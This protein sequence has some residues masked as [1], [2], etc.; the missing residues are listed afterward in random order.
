MA[1]VAVCSIFGLVVGIL[2][3]L[4]LVDRDNPIFTLICGVLG[5]TVGVWFSVG[6]I[7]LTGGTTFNAVMILGVVLTTVIVLLLVLTKI[8]EV[9]R[10][11]VT[12]SHKLSG[13]FAFAILIG[14]AVFLMVSAFPMYSST[15][16][17]INVQNTATGLQLDSSISYPV[18]S[19]V[20]QQLSTVPTC[21]SCG[22]VP[23]DVTVRQ[24]SLNFPFFTSTPSVGD[25]LGLDISFNVG[26]SG[27][28]WA[29]PFIKIAVVHDV[30][31]S[32]TITDA[33][34]FWGS[35]LYKVNKGISKWRTH[36][37]YHE[38]GM[39]NIQFQAVLS[40]QGVMRCPIFHANSIDVWKIDIAKF[41][42]NTPE[43]YLSLTDQISWDYQLTQKE[44][45]TEWGTI[46]K[47]QSSTIN[48]D[49]YCHQDFEGANLLWVGV[50]DAN[51]NECWTTDMGDVL[52]YKI[53][54]FTITGTPDGPTADAHGPYSGQPS[55]NIQFTGSA[56]GG[57]TPYTSWHWAFGDGGSA[58]TQNPV[59]SYSTAGTY[60]ATLTVTDS[61]G[62]TDGD[63]ST[64]TIATSQ[65]DSDGDGIP[66]INDNCPNT[67][68]PNQADA[69]GD[70]IGDACES[71]GQPVVGIDITTYIIAGSLS[72]GCIGTIVYGKKYL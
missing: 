42:H 45:V 46:A 20:V 2:A 16:N 70:G 49:L 17:T 34:D 38:S 63:I 1:Q 14:I 3:S 59:H 55:Q 54:P 67:Y 7:F 65:T 6:W 47:G 41:F 11:V 71:G 28:D 10:L 51:F 58:Y 50:G 26:T 66:D 43:N 69:D 12:T 39:P 8:Q 4:V 29:A 15:T 22:A 19:N 9:L 36:L 13:I 68:N 62:K 72:I 31:N 48:G 30:D 27:G 37:S 24:A 44:S 64:V 56:T 60:T 35:N 25:Y 61:A 40:G 52:S 53:H 21:G 5:A 18:T 57:T 32:G 33:D 23:V